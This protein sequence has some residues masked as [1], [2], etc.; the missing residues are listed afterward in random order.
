MHSLLQALR[1]SKH[2]Q[3]DENDKKLTLSSQ[4]SGLNSQNSVVRTQES[5]LRTQNSE[6]STQHSA[7]SSDLIHGAIDAGSVNALPSH[8]G[9]QE[10]HMV[11]GGSKNQCWLPLFNGFSHQPQ[12]SSNL[13]F[14]S[15]ESSSVKQH[16]LWEGG[17]A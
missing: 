13:V 2:G 6:L 3:A 14:S 11:S 4:N 12:Q 17:L 9:M 16:G 1:H 8:Q 10:L 7:L 15:A 5:T